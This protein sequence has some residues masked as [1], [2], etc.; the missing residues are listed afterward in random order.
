MEDGQ[1]FVVDVRSG[2]IVSS[3]D[4]QSQLPEVAWVTSEQGAA[5]RLVVS[6]KTAL[7][8]YTVTAN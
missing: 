4:G 5:P 8:A 6:T 2:T 3:I 1:V 7:H